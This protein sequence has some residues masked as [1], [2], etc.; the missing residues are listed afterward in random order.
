MV[1]NRISS[2][3]SIRY[4]LAGGDVLLPG[5]VKKALD[6][7]PGLTLFNGY[8]PTENTTFTA[9]YKMTSSSVIGSSVPIGKPIDNTQVYILNQHLQPVPIGVQGE[10]YTGGDGLARGYWNNPE[11]TQE[12]FIDNPFSSL[13]GSKL[14]KTG[15]IVSWQ[16]DGAIIFIGRLDTQVKIRG[17]RIELSEIENWLSTYPGI[18]NCAVIAKAKGN[19]KYLIAY[20]VAKP[21]IQGIRQ[22][23]DHNVL[24]NWLR[25][26]LPDYMIPS[27]FAHLNEL[28]VTPNGKT[29]RKSLAEHDF[30]LER[31]PRQC[32]P[33]KTEY[34]A[35]LLAIWQEV[36]GQNT[37][38][39]DDGFF[40]VGGDSLLAI[41]VA[42]RIQRKIWNGF[43][44]TALFKY[45][46]IRE[47]D[48]YISSQNI[49]IPDSTFADRS[50]MTDLPDIAI[51]SN[52]EEHIDIPLE[53]KRQGDAPQK[54]EA[55]PDYYKNSLAIVGIS[56]RFP[57]ANDSAKFWRNLKEGKESI[58]FFSREELLQAGLSEAVINH[59]NFVPLNSA[60]EHKDLFDADFFTIPP[61]DVELM[62]PQLRLLLMHSWLAIEDAGYTPKTIPNTAVFI[63][64]S[65]YSQPGSI[66][67]TADRANIIHN[68]DEYVALIL[69]QSGTIP[70]MISHKVGL[71]GPSFFIHSNCSSSLSGLY[72]AA[73][74]LLTGDSE[75]ALVGAAN[76]FPP[77]NMGY[78]YQPGLNFSSDGH[79][80]AFD[81]EADGMIAGEGVA[82]I[83]LKRAL[84]AIEA[85]DH[86]YALLRGIRLNNDGS[87]KVGFY[88]PSVRGQ[89]EVIHKVLNS[90]GVNP[91]S[92]GMV[93]AHGTGTKLGDPI[94]FNALNEVY[95]QYSTKK[96]FCGLG[97]VKSNI[98]HLDTA[99]GL[100]GCIKVALS[101]YHGEIP[102]TVNYKSPNPL[103]QLGDS[104]FY[105]VD[106]LKKW[107]E[108]KTPRRAALSSFGL[109]GTNAHAI[110]EEYDPVAH[111]RERLSIKS[112]TIMATCIPLSARDKE[113]LRIYACKL[114][115]FLES[116]SAGCLSFE[117][118][119]YTL[120][121]GRE[122]MSH[123]V[124]F[125]A[126]DC[127]E[128]LA[129][130]HSYIDGNTK[131]DRWLSGEVGSTFR[132]FEK[133]PDFRML[134][135]TWI[136]KKNISRL[137]ELW[138]QGLELDWNQ[139]YLD[140]KPSRISLPTYPFAETVYPLPGNNNGRSMQTPKKNPDIITPVTD[141]SDLS[142]IPVWEP[143]PAKSGSNPHKTG[144]ILVV[145]FGNGDKLA[146]AIASHHLQNQHKVTVIQIQIEDHTTEIEKEYWTID[147][148]DPNGF[149]ACLDKYGYIDSLFFICGL[150][151]NQIGN[152]IPQNAVDAN[153][154][155]IQLLRLAK[156][157][158]QHNPSEHRMDCFII[159]QDIYGIGDEPTQYYGGG[160]TGLT[161]AMAQSF[162][163]WTVRNIDISSEDLH[164]PEKQDT[165]LQSIL[166]EKPSFRGE[167]IKLKDNTR[168]EQHLFKT[169]WLSDSIK[170]AIRHEGVYVIA[171]GRGSVGQII[172]RR[173]IKKYR[174]KVIWIGRQPENDPAI[175]KVKEHNCFYGLQPEYIQ[176][177]ITDFSQL[178][179]SVVRINR[180]WGKI[181]GAIFSC[182]VVAYDNSVENTSEAEF[183]SILEVK[184]IG[185]INFYNS[186]KEQSLDF[187]CYFSSAQGFSFSG[188]ANLSAYASGITFAD[189]YVNHIRKSSIFPVGIINWGFWLIPKEN[190][191]EN[192]FQF[193]NIGFIEGNEGFNYFEQYTGLL[194][195]GA[196]G[197]M[198]CLRI[199]PAVE[200]VMPL[201][202]KEILAIHSPG[203]QPALT[204][205]INTLQL[206]ETDMKAF[207]VSI[208]PD[209]FDQWMTKLLFHQMC[210][211][212]I[213]QEKRE[214]VTRSVLWQKANVLPKYSRFL[215]EVLEILHTWK[216]ISIQ[217]DSDS[218]EVLEDVADA[219]WQS[220]I[221]QWHVHRESVLN[222]SELKMHMQLTESCMMN[223]P[224]ILRGEAAATAIIFP[225]ASLES[226]EK[227][228]KNNA[229]T[230]YFNNIIAVLI[231]SYIRHRLQSD[232]KTKI[233]II[234][235]GAGIGSTSAT[236][237]ERLKPWSAVI[238]YC[239][240]DISNAFLLFA[241]NKY[242]PHVLC[243]DCRFWDI[244]KPPTEQGIEAGYYDI[245]IAAN[246][247]HATPD[248]RQSLRHAKMVLKTNGLLL[249]NEVIV[250]T[251]IATLSFGLTDGWWLFNDEQ[252][253]IP[254]SPVL[255]L[256]TW[257]K[258]LKEEGFRNISCP[259]QSALYAGQQIII[260]ESD[261][262]IRQKKDTGLSP[263][264]GISQDERVT[265][266]S[267]IPSVHSE[268]K[269]P[270]PASTKYL[271]EQNIQGKDQNDI[272]RSVIVKCLSNSLKRPEERI[273]NDT[274]FSDYGV[275]SIISVGFVNQVG[276]MLNIE[277]NPSV[278]FNY[279][280]VKKLADYIMETYRNQLKMQSPP[281]DIKNLQNQFLSGEISVDAV[282]EAVQP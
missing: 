11:L 214:K 57:G 77:R 228:Y 195:S 178:Q 86:I 75:A 172:T 72:A 97:S 111:H 189:A 157:I 149:A 201:N 196:V 88:A 109:G 206:P 272:V 52:R 188:A 6:S 46:N 81:A 49:E 185:S 84:D 102:P 9:L 19:S 160:L 137:A 207:L 223:L 278:I 110:F 32:S 56:C 43:S 143:V 251:T 94:E 25:T 142:L 202:K 147:Q 100:A 148:N 122:S 270:V 27:F 29:D 236:L 4:M 98:G 162:H 78:M 212:G 70:T 175:A 87:D 141:G 253:R 15:D 59:P 22:P 31:E 24:K 44:V 65:G 156:F 69:A 112:R 38:S 144:T 3:L 194:T 213:F 91:E 249:I 217:E 244:S 10:L 220:V 33:I 39:P 198:L 262:V 120:Q 140:N 192:T 235:I 267:S 161:Y 203:N 243:L 281:P 191:A 114:I 242:G 67:N 215:S 282:L 176:A 58:R 80:R 237:F 103:I 7:I 177:D 127:N 119:A 258:V 107:D 101:L 2:L 35:Q 255:S 248:I 153:A 179:A 182:V 190:V 169:K 95:R 53:T 85:G 274:A 47:L 123:R 118:L 60:I 104:P 55:C 14:Y 61:K 167:I 145:S 210:N 199:S 211:M 92:I 90:T 229:L 266:Y 41:T 265:I 20:Y 174:A 21:G 239:Y 30:V 130:L 128:L 18:E 263:N 209:V 40:D 73:Q 108:N 132:I 133:D 227:V 250:K 264:T 187:L 89:S 16:P 154:P 37:I 268:T 275:D 64:A 240:T 83:V 99:A 26:H 246:V 180:Q 28:P 121:T 134:L 219:D 252:L 113:C 125:L 216:F 221:D 135:Q 45:P 124:V 233:R 241:Q 171:G 1:E 23:L 259:A 51:N 105:V 34:G 8:G 245:V 63:S 151:G 159:T 12:K 279:A 115:H 152:E 232:T 197:Q 230:D 163:Q 170:P 126:Q 117:N 204:Q 62:D 165:L 193:S 150:S 158:K 234:E 76:I 256:D 138:V 5:H 183:R 181:H 247:L 238:E 226:V 79:C 260:S 200:T 74:C 139:L 222:R 231:E 224:A 166:D 36:L 82:V 269:I 186:F 273:E 116:N 155:E 146:A 50:S 71:R 205:V 129:K 54:P 271:H 68:A 184:T 93:E 280:T 136:E 164:I 66:S 208:N 277:L 276:E 48:A 225:D 254:G 13:P 257:G 96:Q 261:G 17:F 168:Y 42:D 106:H 173:L 218:V 131:E